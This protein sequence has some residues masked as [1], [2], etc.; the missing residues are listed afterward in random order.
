MANFRYRL[1]TTLD[2]LATNLQALG[3]LNQVEFLICDWGSEVPLH[4]ELSLRP[5]TR[6]ICSYLIVPPAIALKEQKDS[7][8]PIVLA[9]NAVIR[10]AQ[11]TFIMQTDSDVVFTTTFLRGLW[12]LL[13]GKKSH[14][15]N[16]NRALIGSKRKQI[17]WALISQSPPREVLLPLLDQYGPQ[18]PTDNDCGFGFCTTGMMLM[19]RDCW[20]EMSGYDEKLI[21]WG[22]MEIDLGFRA[23]QRMPWFD[24]SIN[25]GLFMYHMEHYSPEN[26]RVP[27]RKH[28]PQSQT[29]A[30]RPNPDNWGLADYDLEIFSYPKSSSSDA[31]SLLA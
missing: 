19:H 26:G 12:E 11:G 17:P 5:E 14:Y 29:N 10:R 21:H 4:K 16:V 24:M 27:N 8:F 7:V 18:F 3:L 28:N 20:H 1:E 23:T 25:F 22:W 15:V 9:Q 30:F 31:T 2:I 13:S 6:A